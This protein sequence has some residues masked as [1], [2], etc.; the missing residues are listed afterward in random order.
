MGLLI[1][2]IKGLHVY[3]PVIKRS[4]A[5]AKGCCQAGISQYKV[6]YSNYK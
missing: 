3:K 6:K 5:N 2:I 4:I 1:K